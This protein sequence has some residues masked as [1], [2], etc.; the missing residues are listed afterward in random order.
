MDSQDTED[1]QGP[2]G[3]QANQAKMEMEADQE[4]MGQWDSPESLEEKDSRVK[5]VDQEALE[6]TESADRRDP[7]E[8]RGQMDHPDRMGHL[9]GLDVMETSDHKEHLEDV[10]NQ[11]A[12]ELM[13]SLDSLE[14]LDQM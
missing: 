7:L 14:I 12:Q 2:Q 11:E 4:T 6:E 1:H 5:P 13:D 3:F 8:I 9:D 10:E